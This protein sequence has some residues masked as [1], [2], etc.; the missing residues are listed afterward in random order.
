MDKKLAEIAEI[1]DLPEGTVKWH[2]SDAKKLLKEGMKQARA[3]GSLGTEPIKLTHLGHVGSPGQE[4]TVDNLLNSKLHQNIAYAAY[5]EPKTIDE[6]AKELNVSPVFVEDEITYLEEW[7][8]LDIMPGQ[9]YRTNVFIQCAPCEVEEQR[10]AMD[11]EVAKAV[12]DEYVPQLIELAKNY[13][14]DHVCVPE[15][16]INYFLWSLIPMAVTQYSVNEFDWA[17]L[18]ANHYMVKRKDGGDYAA[19]ASLYQEKVEE[20]LKKE[21]LSGPMYKGESEVPIFAWELSTAFQDREF[22][23]SDNTVNDYIAFD[24]YLKGNLPKSEAVLDKY[25]R[26]YDRGLLCQENDH[27]NI[28]VVKE[29]LEKGLFAQI[30]KYA[31]TDLSKIDFCG[32]LRNYMPE[33]PKGVFEKIDEVCERRI[34]LEKPYFPKH[35]HKA[36]EIYR[37]ARKINVIMVIEELI[38]RGILKPL[39]D[40]QKKAS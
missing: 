18:R 17:T 14:K 24:M 37:H 4:G 3:I 16:D 35:M 36:L 25:V 39:S 27:V 32:Y 22:D 29:D 2:L 7:G 23:W 13:E 34:A 6:I 30:E 20:I 11:A 19:E 26:L 28:I 5:F 8:I 15:D 33:M 12:C 31:E 21:R 1:L 38:E 40:T 9:K 10:R